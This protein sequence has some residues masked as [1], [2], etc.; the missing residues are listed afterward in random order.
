MAL[1]YCLTLSF[2]GCS[3]SIL[4]PFDTDDTECE[5]GCDSNTMIIGCDN[6]M[7]RPD[8]IDSTT[9]EP[10]SFTG[11]F[12]PVGCTGTL[13]ADKYVLTAAHCLQNLGRNPVGFALGQKAQHFDQ[14]PFGTHGVRRVFIPTLYQDSNN[15]EDQ[16]YDYAIAELWE[17]VQGAT[18]AHW[19]HIDWDDVKLKPVFT[20]G[21]PG[22][23]PDGGI[24]GRAW[25]TEGAHHAAQPFGWIDGGESG[26]LYTNVDGTGGQ[27]GSPVYSF[28]APSEHNQGAGIIR[29]VNGVLI[30]SPVAA[31]IENQNWVARLTPGAVEHIENVMA[32]NTI[33]FFW[34]VIDLP[35]SPTTA[36]ME[37]WP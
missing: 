9:E 18:P 32:P 3:E 13:I 33:D 21:Y 1:I 7:V 22:T 27:S 34:K 36:Q 37:P 28:L 31:C 11:R 4:W 20:A 5:N 17:P 10:W 30:G 19:G 14:R 29:K 15:E 23:Q 12:D 25:F 16:A 26:L 8:D 2:I 6:R 24:L 35:W